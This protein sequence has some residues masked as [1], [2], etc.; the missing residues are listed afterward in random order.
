M[1]AKAQLLSI[2]YFC[3]PLSWKRGDIK[4]HSSVCPSLCLSLCP[5][6]TKTLTWL[7]S[8]EVLKI[9][10]WYLAWI[11]LVTSPFYWYHAVT[12][13]LTFDLLQG[14]ICCR[15]GDHNSSN[16]VVDFFVFWIQWNEV[17]RTQHITESIENASGAWF[18]GI[19]ITTCV[20]FCHIV[21][22]AIDLIFLRNRRVPKGDLILEW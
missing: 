1:L 22:I 2:L 15:A 20:I 11:I 4:S 5:S 3:P 6:V 19:M 17:I 16:L 9:E 21:D 8:S 10:H 18:Y 14:Q 7:I 13:T 12:L